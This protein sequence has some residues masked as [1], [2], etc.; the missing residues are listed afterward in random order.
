MHR[1]AILQT[2]PVTEV[3]TRPVS[4]AVARLVGIRNVFD[5]SVL[6]ERG[7][8]GVL[9]IGWRGCRLE[10]QLLD[11]YSAGER[12]AWCIPADNVIVHRRDRPSR[13]EHENPVRGTVRETVRLGETTEIVVEIGEGHPLHCSIPTHVARRNAIE[14]GVA[15]GVSLKSDAIQLMRAESRNDRV[16]L[17][18]TAAPP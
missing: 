3:M 4:P 13:G 16:S 2:G 5:A 6:R 17:A 18:E 11:G 12:V 1:G 10:T 14:P 15:I 8:G 9:L 7:P